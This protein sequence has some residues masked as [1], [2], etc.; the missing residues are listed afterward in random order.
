MNSDAP[1][2]SAV[3]ISLISL[4]GQ[5]S[6]RKSP[7]PLW[8][9]EGGKTH[10]PL[11]FLIKLKKNT[12]FYF[13]METYIVQLAKDILVRVCFET[14]VIFFYCCTVLKIYQSNKGIH[15]FV[16]IFH[17]DVNRMQARSCLYAKNQLLAHHFGK[18]IIVCLH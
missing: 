2:E 12:L 8:K 7:S 9:V 11:F 18:K 5:R 10:S 14:I 4:H 17:K 13:I 15:F 1:Y 3:R 16:Y 6:W